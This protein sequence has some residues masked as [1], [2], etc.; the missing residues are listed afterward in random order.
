MTDDARLDL[1][2]MHHYTVTTS[3]TLSPSGADSRVMRMW[4]HDIPQMAF[5]CDYVMNAMLAVSAAH[6]YVMFPDNLRYLKASHDHL[7][8]SVTKYYGSLANLD[9]KALDLVFCASTLISFHATLSWRRPMGE[10][11][12]PPMQWFHMAQVCLFSFDKEEYFQSFF[13]AVQSFEDPQACC[14]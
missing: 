4:S 6:L 2:L 9:V 7:G 11:Y 14:A 3:A 13:H 1:R 5:D 8:L 10:T 12:M